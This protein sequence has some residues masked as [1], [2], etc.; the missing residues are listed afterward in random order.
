MQ[1]QNNIEQMHAVLPRLPMDKNAFYM[2]HYKLYPK[3]ATE[4]FRERI[5]ALL[6][7]TSNNYYEKIIAYMEPLKTLSTD[8]Y[9]QGLLGRLRSQFKRRRNFMKLLDR[10]F[11]SMGDDKI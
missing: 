4:Y 2:K 9:F 1:K 10:Y 8:A 6:P 5:N 7:Y 11:P 3:E